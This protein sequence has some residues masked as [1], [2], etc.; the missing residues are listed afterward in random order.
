MIGR[1]D[2]AKEVAAE[3]EMDAQIIQNLFSLLL[4]KMIEHL[5]NG[6]EIH[7]KSFGSFL[8]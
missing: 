3:I 4:D 5:Q 8:L 2:L 1:R 6:E 7:F